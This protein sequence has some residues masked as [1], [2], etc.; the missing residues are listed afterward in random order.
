VSN[1]NRRGN[2]TA[3][4]PQPGHH[5]DA[6]PKLTIRANFGSLAEIDRIYAFDFL[7]KTAV[8]KFAANK[9]RGDLARID[10]IC[11]REVEILDDQRQFVQDIDAAFIDAADE[12]LN[13]EDLE[14]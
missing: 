10:L 2:P 9:S 6:K 1:P 14:V 8:V 13:H 5:G 11:L 7:N 12:V 3:P 4:S